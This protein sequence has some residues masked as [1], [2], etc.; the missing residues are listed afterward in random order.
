LGF[1]N[2][3]VGGSSPP[4]TTISSPLIS[5]YA[6]FTR[7]LKRGAGFGYSRLSKQRLIN[8]YFNILTDDFI[9]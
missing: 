8:C 3:G 6:T 4:M 5:N 2:S 9:I 7:L 1:H